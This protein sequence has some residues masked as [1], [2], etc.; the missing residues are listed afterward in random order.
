M[1]RTIAGILLAGTI[2]SLPVQTEAH[3]RQCPSPVVLSEQEAVELMQVAWCEAGN[4]GV[5]GQA[6]VMSVILNRVESPEW[7]DNVHDV[8]HESGQFATKRMSKADITWETHYA[9]AEIEAG[10][11]F[12]D[13]IGFERKNST[14]LDQFFEESFVYR[15]HT[16]YVR[17][18]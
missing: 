11:I 12:P 3:E 16:F 7:P 13:I 18:K 1:R 10:N 17:K 4:Q 14:V 15:D 5:S 9:L 6:Y 2:M 8:I